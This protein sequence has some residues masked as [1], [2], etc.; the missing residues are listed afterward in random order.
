MGNRGR[1]LGFSVFSRGFRYC[2]FMHT[3]TTRLATNDAHYLESGIGRDGRWE[4]EA[5]TV[6]SSSLHTVEELLSLRTLLTTNTRGDSEL[7]DWSE[8]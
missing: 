4:F 2:A 7:V 3:L 8:E 1:I 6:A 5:D